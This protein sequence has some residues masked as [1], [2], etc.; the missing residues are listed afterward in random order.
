M[1]LLLLRLFWE[2][3][4]SWLSPVS[5][6]FI[7]FQ[8][9]HTRIYFSG[10][11]FGA[12]GGV[13]VIVTFINFV[14]LHI[15]SECMKVNINII[16]IKFTLDTFMHPSSRTRATRH[17]RSPPCWHPSHQPPRHYN[18]VSIL[19]VLP[20]ISFPIAPKT[21]VGWKRYRHHPRRHQTFHR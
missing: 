21:R 4:R 1:T 17:E 2:A 9:S 6:N 7:Y 8:Q 19:A 15:D 11:Q 3:S 10:R 14:P 13:P 16:L 18:L 5:W 20:N 12:S